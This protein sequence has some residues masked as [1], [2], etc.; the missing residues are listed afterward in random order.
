MAQTRRACALFVAL[1]TLSACG[2]A[3]RSNQV[4]SEVPASTAGPTLARDLNLTASQAADPSTVGECALVESYKTMPPEGQKAVGLP[5]TYKSVRR[6]SVEDAEIAMQIGDKYFT[7]HGLPDLGKFVV[8]AQPSDG[9]PGAVML[10]YSFDR[11]ID[12]PSDLGVMPPTEEGIDPPKTTN[13]RE[14]VRLLVPASENEKAE[15]FDQSRSTSILV[16]TRETRSVVWVVPSRSSGLCR[17]D[18]L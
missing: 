2:N 8:Y 14:F 1:A 7:S 17:T 9:F 16:D 12:L 3:E 13:V 11:L 15:V 4:S 18:G 6:V 10:H 5:N